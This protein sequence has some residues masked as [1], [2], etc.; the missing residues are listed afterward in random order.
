M[1]LYEMTSAAQ[2]LYAML[3]AEVIDEQTVSDTLESLNV[4]DKLEDYCKVIRQFEADAAAYKVEADRFAAKKK[5]AENAIE[6]LK[7]AIMG[8]MS[9]VGEE[10]KK[11]GVFDVKL[12]HSKAVNIVNENDIPSAYRVAQPDKIDKA[13][14]RKALLAGE[15]VAGAII[16]VNDNISIK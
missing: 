2:E 9:A 7:A 3:D 5:S 10:K 15:E 1:T 14:I 13:S 11:C 4:A 12:S 6:R 16:Q 8:Y